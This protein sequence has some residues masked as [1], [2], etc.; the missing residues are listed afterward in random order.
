MLR[1]ILKSLHE[2]EA[3][4]M[5]E[6]NAY[7]TSR[8]EMVTSTDDK[9]KQL[10]VIIE[11]KIKETET[12]LQ[13][14]KERR[15]T[16]KGGLDFANIY[17]GEGLYVCHIQN[18][19]GGNILM[20][21]V[22][23]PT[24]IFV[25]QPERYKVKVKPYYNRRAPTIRKKWNIYSS[26]FGNFI[27]GKL[28]GL[29]VIRYNDTSFYEGPYIDEKWLDNQG[30]VNLD[31][32][33]K[34]HYGIYTCSDRRVFEG[35]NVDNHFDPH[36]LQMFYRCTMPNGEVYEGEFCDEMYHGVG[37]YIYKDGAVYEG[38]WH[39][40][41]RFGHG[42]F[43]ASPA[44][45]GWAYEGDWDTD[46]KHGEGMITWQDS[47]CYIGEW[48]YDVREGRGVFVTRLRDV[49]KGEFS[50]NMFHGNGELLYSD[51]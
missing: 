20:K 9:L 44:S 30:I 15:N 36:N 13:F 4:E 31:G 26:I 1:D 12:R 24:V 42:H 2:K 22:T 33:P 19:R 48:Y 14:L 45:G 37:M 29:T 7:Y 32:K 49:Y 10:L 40:G 11:S 18:V 50:K 6:L 41:S 38:N 23:R 8:N 35:F 17:D 34:N 27:N 47:S 39:K 16:I 28:S 46:R 43:R 25:E 51:G 3:V 21:K 5:K